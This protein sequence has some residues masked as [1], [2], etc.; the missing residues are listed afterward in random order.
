F[1]MMD[2]FECHYTNGTERVRFLDRAIY[3][4]QQDVHFDSDVGIYVAD[5][6][7]GK[8][9]ASYWN[10]LPDI[11]EDRRTA[12]DRFCRHNYKV[13]TPFITERR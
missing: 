13:S 1:Q 3:N 12:V 4:R 7:M 8:P 10:S 11:L 9:T 2:K 6:P 5:T